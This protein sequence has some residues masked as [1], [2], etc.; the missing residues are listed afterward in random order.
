M[1]KTNLN[2]IPVASKYVKDNW[3]IFKEMYDDLGYSKDVDIKIDCPKCFTTVKIDKIIGDTNLELKRNAQIKQE[4]KKEYNKCD[5]LLK[6]HADCTI[7][8]K[9]GVY[10]G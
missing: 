8:K 3:T 6:C 4:P 10:N 5:I 1:E 9:R 7:R 2:K